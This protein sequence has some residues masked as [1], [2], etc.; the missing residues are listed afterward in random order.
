LWIVG[1][2]LALLLGVFSGILEFVPIV[3]PVA[4]AVPGIIMAMS[5]GWTKALYAVLVY[6]IVQQAENH[7]LIPL[8][9]RKAVSLPPALVVLAVVAMGLLF[10]MLGV[11]VA[12][13]LTA[14]IIV[15]IRMLYIEDVLGKGRDMQ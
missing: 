15:W 14:V 7:V 2:P 12:T 4:G 5:G 6:F 9:Q 11:L 10:G 13:P 1:V 3:G 8:I